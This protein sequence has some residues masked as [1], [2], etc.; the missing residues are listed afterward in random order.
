MKPTLRSLL[1]SLRHAGFVVLGPT[2][3][4]TLAL[5][6]RNARAGAGGTSLFSHES[7]AFLGKARQAIYSDYTALA[8]RGLVYKQRFL[9]ATCV[10]RY[11]FVPAD[12]LAEDAGRRID[13][14][15]KP[16]YTTVGHENLQG[17][18]RSPRP[19]RPRV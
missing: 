5:V 15:G 7:L 4:R 11:R 3:L 12:K 13:H 9:V 14:A 2:K 1:Q 18:G 8:R 17:G 19:R 16:A 6:M 10:P